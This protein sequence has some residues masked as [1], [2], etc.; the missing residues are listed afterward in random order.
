MTDPFAG[1]A[2]L[3]LVLNQA[4]TQLVLPRIMRGLRSTRAQTRANALQALGHCARLHGLIDA[5]SIAVLRRALRDR[6]PLGGCQLRGYAGDAADDIGNVRSAT[7]HAPLAT[8]PMCR[9]PVTGERAGPK[10]TS[11]SRT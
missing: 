4:E 5:D 7:P 1:V 6:T 2:L 11:T 9:A 3:V 8:S 10:G